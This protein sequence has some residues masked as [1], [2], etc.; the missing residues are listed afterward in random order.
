[1]NSDATSLDRLRD[2]VVPPATPWWPPAPG[3]YWVMGGV[4]VLIVMLVLKLLLWW[5]KN[6]YRREALAELARSEK[7]LA[8][9]T[10][11]AARLALFAELL[12]RAALSAWPRETVASLTDSSWIAFLDRSGQAQP[13]NFGALLE[14]VAYDPRL[15]DDLSEKQIQELAVRV[16]D[17][18]KHHHVKGTEVD[19]P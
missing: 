7:L 11:R 18:L 5:Q 14:R 15:A 1:M 16:R 2:I 4:A 12:K 9:P 13:S 17:W 19:Q 3:W 6:R 8:D 10:Q